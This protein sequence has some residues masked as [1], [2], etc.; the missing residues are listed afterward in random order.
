[1]DYLVRTRVCEGQWL[2]ATLS[3]RQAPRASVDLGIYLVAE[4]PVTCVVTVLWVYSFCG[5]RNIR[6]PPFV[7]PLTARAYGCWRDTRPSSL[8]IPIKQQILI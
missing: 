3:D 5:L 1:M 6:S 2:D 8:T 4:T 7:L